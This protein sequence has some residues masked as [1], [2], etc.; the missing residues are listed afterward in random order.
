M[1]FLRDEALDPE[2]PATMDARA[3][4]YIASSAGPRLRDA[5]LERF[6][7]VYVGCIH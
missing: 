6:G 5:A 2:D 3:G 4:L 7:T 1:C